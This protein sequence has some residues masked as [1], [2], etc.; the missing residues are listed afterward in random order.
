MFGIVVPPESEPFVIA[1]SQERLW[2]LLAANYRRG[3]T[4]QYVVTLD[5]RCLVCDDHVAGWWEVE[6]DGEYPD[7]PL[8]DH[9]RSDY[10]D[11]QHAGI[12]V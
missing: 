7:P 12:Y 4:R 11:E 9:C 5:P 2:P 1:D 3:H 8:H 10:L 6:D